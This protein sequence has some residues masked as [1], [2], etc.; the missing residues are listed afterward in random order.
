[1]RMA[2]TRSPSFIL[3]IAVVLGSGV[4]E[5][6]DWPQWLGPKRDA[7]WR[8]TGLL[9]RFPADGPKFLWKTP[10]G[11]G[12]SGPAVADGFVYVMDRQRPVDAD[13]KPARVTR[14]GVPGKERVLCLRAADGKLVWKYE[15]DCPYKISY[16]SGP[17]TTPLVHQGSVYTLGAMGDLCRL[18]ALTGKVQWS[19]NLS[20][21]YKAKPPAWGWAAHPL[22]EGDLLY[23]LVG[24]PGSAVVAFNKDN[25]KEAWR[26][27][28]TEEVGYSPPM[29]YQAGGKR[30]LI[31]WLSESINSLDPA[32]GQVYWTQRYPSTV[33]P[34]RPAV[35]IVTVRRMDDL[36]FISTYYH[37]PM[38]LKLA[39]D[40]PAASV[41][42][43]GKSNNVNKPDGLH[44]LMVTPVLKDGYIYGVCANG[45]LRCL[46]AD[47]GKQL[48]QTYAATAG[49]KADSATAFLVEQGGRFV[50]F[51][52]QGDLILAELRPEGYRE[53][54]R[55]HILEPSQ[56]ARG[57]VVVWS[58]PAFAQRCVFARNDKEIVCVSLAANGAS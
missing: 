23:S 43:Q 56:P 47:T 13:G 14:A 31:I 4:V 35:N 50:I 33:P 7:V 32:T 49:K 16:A 51:N 9:E 52:D 17:R 11:T 10:L 24:G 46:R 42:W 44:S 45:E 26:A 8:E 27:L 19:K 18:E 36:L 22:I 53:I 34:E 12:Y 58:H 55:A 37:G 5:A 28:T 54:D 41:L 40:R 30:Q 57:R 38:M 39:A 15:Y 48:W 29:I 1:M 2:E 20:A 3:S 25:G 6:N 21:E